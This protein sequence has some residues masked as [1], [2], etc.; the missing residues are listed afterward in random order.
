MKEIKD[1]QLIASYVK[2]KYFISTIYREASTIE[3]MWY[4][5]TMVWEWNAKTKERGAILE[6]QDSGC[7]EEMALDNHCAMAKKFNCA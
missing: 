2:Q 6:Q 1:Y 7:D 4:F 3:P 5:E